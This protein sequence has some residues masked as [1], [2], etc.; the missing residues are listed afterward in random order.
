MK[1]RED[2]RQ[3]QDQ[4][5]GQGQ[6]LSLLPDQEKDQEKDQE[7]SPPSPANPSKLSL[8]V[9]LEQSIGYAQNA[10]ERTDLSRAV[11]ALA[12][13]G[14]TPEQVPALVATWP[15][16]WGPVSWVSIARN[17]TRLSRIVEARSKVAPYPG[18]SGTRRESWPSPDQ[19]M[20]LAE[21]VKSQGFDSVR[22]LL[23]ARKVS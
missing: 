13:S 14:C 4:G 20:T 6:V 11:R 22:E 8:R 18:L 17:F 12:E 15:E 3:D 2:Q 10:L 19:S 7:I 21:F 1:I 9:A 16:G 5:Q 23:A